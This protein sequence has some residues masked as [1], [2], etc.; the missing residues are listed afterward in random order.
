MKRKSGLADSPFFKLP[1]PVAEPAMVQ[2]QPTP[3]LTPKKIPLIKQPKPH[4]QTNRVTEQQT[5]K[6]TEFVSNRLTELQTY[7]VDRWDNLRRLELRLTREQ[8]R[9]L[10]DLEE[11][12]SNAMPDIE[13]DNPEFQRLTKNSIIRVLVEIAM[14]L[15]MRVDASAFHNEGDLLQAVFTALKEKFATPKVTD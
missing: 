12:I 5:S 7:R 14:Q 9:Y 2:A 10:D 4:L 1:P 8:K 3:T 13:R 11:E 15:D 6:V